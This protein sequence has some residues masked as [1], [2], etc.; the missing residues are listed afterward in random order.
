MTLRGVIKNTK[1][2]D[3]Q[4]HAIHSDKDLI[5]FLH[6]NL[7]IVLQVKQLERKNVKQEIYSGLL[8]MINCWNKKVFFL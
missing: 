7:L 4:L 3:M 5:T 2:C 8:R 1:C 6:G